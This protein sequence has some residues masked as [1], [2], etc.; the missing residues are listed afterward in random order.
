MIKTSLDQSK[1]NLINMLLSLEPES[2]DLEIFIIDDD[3]KKSKIIDDI[4]TKE[5]DF[6]IAVST[7]KDRHTVA[8]SK[9]LKPNN[10]CFLKEN[11]VPVGTTALIIYN[12]LDL[13]VLSTLKVINQ[14]SWTRIY[15]LVDIFEGIEDEDVY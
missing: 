15:I 12:F 4:L 9:N 3:K 14:G 1:Q 10:F 7:A 13:N 5:K 2:V 6:T 8:Y 11:I